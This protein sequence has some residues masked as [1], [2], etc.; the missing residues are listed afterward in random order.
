MIICRCSETHTLKRF[1]KYFAIA[2]VSQAALVGIS[3][4]FEPVRFIGEIFALIFYIEPRVIL[5][6]NPPGVK[7]NISDF[8]LIGI[9]MIFWSVMLSAGVCL[10]IWLAKRDR[11]NLQ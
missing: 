7:T 3:W 8:E 6:P 10:I 11:T 1:L 5:F 4:A 2:L 9:P